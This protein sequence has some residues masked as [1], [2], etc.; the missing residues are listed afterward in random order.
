MAETLW[1]NRPAAG[2]QI[3]YGG[4]LDW[5]TILGVVENVRYLPA[6]QKPGW[7]L[8]WH[9]GQIPT[10]QMQAVIAVRGDPAGYIERIRAAVREAEPQIAIVQIKPIDTLITETLWQSRLWGFLF[11]CFAML[12][13]VLAAFGLYAVM[14][15]VVGTRTREIGIRVAL[16]A[17]P[18]EVIRM[19]TKQGMTL[20]GVG[21][22]TG[23]ALA[24]VRSRV[25]RSV[26]AE[27]GAIE[28]GV[29]AG[30]LAVLGTASL[31]ACV[32]PAVRASRVDPVVA[33]RSE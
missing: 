26:L 31:A 18:V 25:L 6:E 20:V 29:Y 7:E 21:A 15:Y 32:V 24:V 19:V 3:R 11:A 8:Y 5:I 4:G 9:N 14:S 10:P 22:V 30:V 17:K 2:Q 13:L 1:P 23:L 12:A 27:V 33:L 16:G 28:P